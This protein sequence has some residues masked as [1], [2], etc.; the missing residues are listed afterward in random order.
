[1]KCHTFA[2]KADEKAT[3]NLNEQ[4]LLKS[5]IYTQGFR[6][7]C[8]TL[9][10]FRN[11]L[12]L[13]SCSLCFP[14]ATKNIIA[15]KAIAK[16]GISI[17]KIRQLYHPGF[18]NKSVKTGHVMLECSFRQKWGYIAISVDNCSLQ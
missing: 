16:N 10:S 9:Y 7:T 18:N 17:P 13:A 1:M 8:Y 11:A 2:T 14:N 5:L 12:S 4:G 6:K 3:K 15:Y